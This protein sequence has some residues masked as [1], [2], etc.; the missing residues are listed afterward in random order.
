MH[1][2]AGRFT[3]LVAGPNA[4]GGHLTGLDLAVDDADRILVLDPSRQQVRIFAAKEGTACLSPTTD[5]TRRELVHRCVRLL[6]L[7]GLLGFG[8]LLLGHSEPGSCSSP[9][10][11]LLAA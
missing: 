11:K 1:D 10:A 7:G 9:C 6:A 3:A 2:P 5:V 8:G 4:F